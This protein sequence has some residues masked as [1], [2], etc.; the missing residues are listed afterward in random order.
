MSPRAILEGRSSNRPPVLLI[1]G[2]LASGICALVM[3]VVYLS[4]GGVVPTVIG[5]FLAVPTA[6]VL[7]ALV[8]LID[9]L[10][11]EPP[12]T[13]LLAFG[14]GAGVSIVGAWFINNF[15]AG[16]LQQEFATGWAQVITV[17]VVAPIVE[18][19]L[20]G[21]LLLLVFFVRRHE[22]DG[23]TDGIVYASLSALGFALVENVLYYMRGVASPADGD[24]WV[25][26]VVRGMVAPLGH[27]LYTAM[28]GLGVAYAA[29]RRG[30]GGVFAVV[31]GWILA[32]LLH[33]MWNA[34]GYVA[35]ANGLRPLVGLAVAWLVLLFV[36]IG[37][38]VVVVRDRRRTVGLI[39]T[40]LPAYVPSGIVQPQDVQMLGT[41]S[42]R[43]RARKWARSGAGLRGAR[44]MG[45]YQLAATELALLHKHASNRSIE[46]AKFAARRDAILFLMRSARDAFFRRAP[47]V[48]PAPWAQ[49]ERSGFFTPP[50]A[51]GRLPHQPQAGTGPQ[52]PRPAGWPQVPGT[53][54]Q[55]RGPGMPPPSGRPPAGPPVGQVP[56]GPPGPP[57]RP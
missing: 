51:V 54:P 16:Q 44:A 17:S 9:R 18:E 32:V 15:F 47:Q 56:P 50:G 52:G 2:L 26:L 49:H 35:A 20:K 57:P 5:M 12:L 6:V 41:M 24:L 25:M 46:P 29:T 40:H 45:D 22:I 7:I 3:V 34:S 31:G 36:L 39:R 30:A 28:I 27:P 11:P 23:P 48:P 19:S 37:L 4:R 38:A 14:W 43:R 42:G 33:G 10:E 13:M 1:V 21:S 53:P 55:P 8:L